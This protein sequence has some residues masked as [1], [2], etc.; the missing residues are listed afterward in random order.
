MKRFIN[1]LKEVQNWLYGIYKKA[2]QE[3]I[4]KKVI[5]KKFKIYKM[6]D[7]KAILKVIP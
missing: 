1:P 6:F 2:L 7:L 4:K 3:N 5:R